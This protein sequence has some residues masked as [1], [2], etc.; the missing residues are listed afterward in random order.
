MAKEL[1]TGR[2]ASRDEIA[3]LYDIIR[4]PMLPAGAKRGPGLGSYIKDE[5]GSYVTLIVSATHPHEGRRA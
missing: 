4:R 5:L 1:A 2:M 3:R